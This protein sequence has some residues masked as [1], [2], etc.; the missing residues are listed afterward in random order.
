LG[1]WGAGIF[2]NDDASD[3]IYALEDDG[4]K[5][6]DSAL[7][8]ALEGADGGYIEAPDGACALAA[9]EAVSAA[10]GAPKAGL[11]EEQ[12]AAMANS[13]AGIRDLEDVCRR[14]ILATMAVLGQRPGGKQVK[15]ELIGLWGE[16][17]VAEEDFQAFIGEVKDL[18]ARL[19]AVREGGSE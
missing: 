9:A 2:E 1:S 14:A 11:S 6:V 4:A 17:G 7:T 12:A 19:K 3:W 15:S 10:Y 13:A 8:A 5:A 16:D 18:A